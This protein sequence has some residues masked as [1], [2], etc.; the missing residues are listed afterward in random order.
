[1]RH[2]YKFVNNIGCINKNNPRV[3]LII[4]NE[5]PIQNQAVTSY[6]KAKLPAF[7]II[8]TYALDL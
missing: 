4:I 6:Q 2:Y 7:A 8:N 5:K 3:T 1:M